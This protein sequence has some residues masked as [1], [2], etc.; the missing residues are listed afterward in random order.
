MTKQFADRH[1]AG[2]ALADAL[3]ELDLVDPVILALPRGGIPVALPVAQAL[4]APLDL[5][6]VRKL[7]A[8]GQPELAVGAVVEGDPPQT[9]FNPDILT[10]FG[11]KPADLQPQIEEKLTQIA[12]RRRRY[13]GSRAPVPVTGRTAI[14]VDDGIATGAT[15]RAA[16]K[17]LHNREPHAVIL[18]VPVA[19]SEVIA[20]FGD[21]VDVI[22]CLS[23]PQPFFA[24]G[25]HYLRFDQVSDDAAVTLLAEAPIDP[26]TAKGPPS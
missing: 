15:V 18:A 25:A 3:T 5:L 11:L 12:E 21:L 19:P 14:V 8:P 13:L 26:G 7:G 17:A 16:L 4:N 22:V 24:V 2:L 20:S 10:A 6:L 23:Q 9:V 1:T